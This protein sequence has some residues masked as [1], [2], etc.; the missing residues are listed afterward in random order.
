MAFKFPFKLPQRARSP[1]YPEDIFDETRMSFGDHIEELRRRLLLALYGLGFC[2]IIGFVL[3]YAGKSA[4]LENFGIGVPMMN[5]ITEPVESQVRNFYIQRNLRN[6][7]I[8]ESA[9]ERTPDEEAAELRRRVRAADGDLNVLTAEEKKKLLASPVEMPI[10]L[11]TKPL[12]DAG[13]TLKDPTQTEIS[14][15]ARVYPG[16]VHALSNDGESQLGTR[17]YLTTLSAQEAFMVYFKVSLLCGAVIASPWIFYHLWAFVSAGLY[18]HEKKYIHLYLPLSVVLF[19]SGVLLCQ[20]VVLPG[21]VKALLGFNNWIDL[22]PDLRLNEWLG[23]A[24][25]LPV[26]F[27]VSFQA[28]LVMFFLTRIGVCTYKTFLDYWRAA[29]MILAVFSAVIT[30]TPDV[31]TLLYL[32]VPMMGLYLIGILVCYWFPPKTWDEEQEAESQVAV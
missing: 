31:V 20:F 18:P 10:I 19:I 24:L 14:L 30:P 1:E 22:D 23:F 5:V 28:P 29:V 7:L 26:V 11:P 21:A 2:L 6:K 25:L 4:G 15:T 3:D 12:A 32:F 9:S 27:G 17:K 16:H 8:L 13:L